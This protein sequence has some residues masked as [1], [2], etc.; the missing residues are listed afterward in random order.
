MS[1]ILGIGSLSP[2]TRLEEQD[3][4]EVDNSALVVGLIQL[5][6]WLMSVSTFQRKGGCPFHTEATDH[7]PDWFDHF[8]VIKVRADSDPGRK[9]PVPTQADACVQLTSRQHSVGARKYLAHID[10]KHYSR[11]CVFN[12]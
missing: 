11:M 10:A 7:D 6:R 8:L 5:M 12:K 9:E 1:E 3:F 2:S 4:L